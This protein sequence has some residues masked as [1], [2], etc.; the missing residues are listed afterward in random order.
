MSVDVTTLKPGD[1]LLYRPKGIF[2]WIIAAKTWHNVSHCEVYDGAGK[3]WASRD[4]IGVNLYP[5]RDTE[6]AWVLR[7]TMKLNLPW[8]RRWA[9]DRIGTPYGWLDL[10]NFINIPIDAPG[11]VC[12]AFL[13]KFLRQ[14][15]W[16]VF[17][18]DPARKVAP[19]QFLDL[20]GDRLN[21]VYKAAK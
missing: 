1:I 11:I 16:N 3:S 13:T 6:L 18:T 10:L 14:A 8:A 5:W 12:S 17:P 20:I 15:G 19:S 7:P 4:G 9:K 21:I 2:G